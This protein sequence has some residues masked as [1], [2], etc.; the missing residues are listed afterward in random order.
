[1]KNN[2]PTKIKSKIFNLRYS[3]FKPS[4]FVLLNQI[5]QTQ[6]WSDE[7]W[8]EWHVKK[9]KEL[10]LAAFRKTKFYAKFYTDAGFQEGDV[11]QNNFLTKLPILRRQNLRENF[12]EI[13]NL[14]SRGRLGVSTT[15]GSTG[16][17]VKC[18]YDRYFPYEAFAWRTQEWW[19]LLPSDDGAY[20]WRNPYKNAKS[21]LLNQVLWWPTRKIRLDASSMTLR[22]MSAFIKTWNQIKPPQ[23][24]G[25]VGAVEEL[26]LFIEKNELFFHP[27]RAVWV[28]SSPLSSIQRMTMERVYKAPVY[29][30]YG[31]CELPWIA[32]QCEKKSGLHVN[33]EKVWL[34][35]VNYADQEVPLGTWGRTLITRY[36][37]FVFPLIRYEIGDSGRFLK[38]PC[39][40]G[41]T[42]PLIDNVKGRTTDIIRLPS[43][44][45]LSGDYLTTIFDAY[46]DVVRGFRVIQR[47]DSSLVIEY[48]PTNM[49]EV[50]HVIQNIKET[51]DE[52]VCLEVPVLFQKVNSISHDRGKLRFVTR[53]S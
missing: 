21:K 16:V 26:A 34:E 37:D 47:K 29:D 44:R 17:P 4:V 6:F 30:Q 7:E 50:S 32:A 46:P 12:E 10:V 19:G 53:E 9:Q 24:Q 13:V 27:P 33:A 28:T 14:S 51:L 22:S 15:G 11:E 40:C 52:K 42:L 48:I 1:M 41:R 45:I 38:E 31:S 35:H 8:R 49:S 36:D 18:G 3:C 23:L 20:V 5:K 2:A 25:Y 39:P 43:G